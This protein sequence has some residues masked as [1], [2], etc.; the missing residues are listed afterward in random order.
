VQTSL[1]HFERGLASE[2]GKTAGYVRREVE[3]EFEEISAWVRFKN[4]MGSF[5]SPRKGGF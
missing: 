2:Y 3:Y 5:F 4:K 1:K